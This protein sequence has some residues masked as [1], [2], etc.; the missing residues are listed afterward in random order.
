M[1]LRALLAA[2]VLLPA[3]ASF[4]AI[5]DPCTPDVVVEATGEVTTENFTERCEG[6]NAVFCFA[7]DGGAAGSEVETAQNCAALFDGAP[8]GTCEDFAGFGPRCSFADGDACVF[9]S[10]DNPFIPFPCQT[11][12]SGCLN[13]VCTANAGACT[14]ADT[15]SCTPGGESAFCAPWN[16][17]IGNQCAGWATLDEVELGGGT[18]TC[19]GTGICNGIGDGGECSD[20]YT[21]DTSACTDGT[22]G[23]GGEGEG[24]GEGEG[25]DAGG[26]DDPPQPAPTGFCSNMAG[27][28]PAFGS[29]ALV[30]IALRRRR[31]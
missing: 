10:A 30:L 6:A 22:C 31:R 20:F 23:T 7:P 19:T 1:N 16:Q 25:D 18:L 15:G 24:E 9:Q 29:L 21:C 14:P 27:T 2:A 17:L 5:G 26:R 4:A 28:L 3:G 12:T 13:G 8:V 11:D